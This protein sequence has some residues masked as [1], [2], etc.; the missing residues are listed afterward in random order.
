MKVFIS[1]SGD[2]SKQLGEA[3][4]WWLP[5]VLPVEPFFSE[6]D[7]EAGSRW[8]HEIVD[9]LESD[10]GLVILTPENITRQWIMFE[11]GA[12]ARSVTRARVCPILF[13]ITKEQFNLNGGPLAFFQ[14]VEFTEDGL[15]KLQKTINNG[16]LGEA[17]LI[18]RFDVWWPKL[19]GKVET[20]KPAPQPP[21]KEPTT[22]ELL[23]E[24]L[25]LTRAILREFEALPPWQR[26]FIPE[27]ARRLGGLGGLGGFEAGLGGQKPP[28]RGL[29]ELLKDEPPPGGVVG[30]VTKSNE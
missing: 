9:N 15:R 3:I 27:D 7:I 13:D 24:I 16:K 18:E 17:D 10:A 8:Y 6:T 25:G 11:A 30:T 26:M 1:W 19:K 23:G 29:F 21:L 22:N 20:I 2:H 5:K 4:H 12:M 28:V 14:A